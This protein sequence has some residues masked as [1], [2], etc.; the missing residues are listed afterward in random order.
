MKIL[1][2]LHY[3][4]VLT[5]Y[6]ASHAASGIIAPVAVYMYVSLSLINKTI[7]EKKR[8]SPHVVMHGVM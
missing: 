4:C 8:Q 7:I 5:L 3:A 2:C 6:P 1:Y